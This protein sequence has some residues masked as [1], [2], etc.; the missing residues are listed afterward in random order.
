MV[1]A[2][3]YFLSGN[4]EEMDGNEPAALLHYLSSFCASC[5][6]NPQDRP[7]GTV[8]KIRRL[9]LSLHLSDAQLL[10]MVHSYGVLTDQECRHLL[11]YSIYGFLPGIYT[12]ISGLSYGH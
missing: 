5:N 2:K 1:N 3:T 4:K 9:Q 12:V 6:L 7:Y 8:A 11:Y 10:D